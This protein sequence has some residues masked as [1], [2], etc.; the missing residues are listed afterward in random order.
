MISAGGRREHHSFTQSCLA[1]LSRSCFRRWALMDGNGRNR[2]VME[3]PENGSPRIS[4]LDADGKI[5]SEL[6]PAKAK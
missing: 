3:V 6:V 1:I 5:L 2:L 4:F